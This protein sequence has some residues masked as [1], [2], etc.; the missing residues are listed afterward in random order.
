[1]ALCFA[2]T[3]GK[4]GTGKS[5]VSSGL[6]LA[7]SKLNKKVLVLDLDEGLRCL[8]LFFGIDKDIVFDLSD[9]FSGRSAT[10]VIYK[11]PGK[12]SISIV[13]APATA[14]KIDAASLA[15]F[16]TKQ[17]QDYDII[18]LDMPAGVDLSALSDIA[19]ELFFITVSNADPV[20]VRDAA[21]IAALLPEGRAEPRLIINR[22]EPKL[23]KKGLYD[24]IDVIIDKSC[25]RLIGIVPNDTE[26]L[27][28]PVNHNLKKNGKAFKALSRIAL[29]LSGADV[30]LP[31]LS[32]I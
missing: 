28:L 9:A 32:K 13:P 7:F 21:A 1:M 17:R 30:Q 4:G 18:I 8:D 27:L 15:D 14:N 5:T 3:S 20:S 31:K 19:S 24:N 16:I 12:N 23:I 2:V 6:A 22:F 10:D 29:R 26:L 25:L 11:V